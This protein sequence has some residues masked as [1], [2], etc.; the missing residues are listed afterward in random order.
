MVDSAL[1]FIFNFCNFWEEFD[2][3]GNVF[4]TCFGDIH[5]VAMIIFQ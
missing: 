1:P 5:Y 4:C 3:I 2:G